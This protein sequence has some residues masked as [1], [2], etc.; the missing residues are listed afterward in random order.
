MIASKLSK[1]I[2]TPSK[3]ASILDWNKIGGAIMSL[4]INSERIGVAIAE[5]PN[6]NNAIYE[7]NPIQASSKKQVDLTSKFIEELATIVKNHKVC[8]FVVNWPLQPEG[9]MGKSCGK[10]LHTLD[11][12]ANQSTKVLS[13]SRPFTLLDDRNV[14][15]II[16]TD[17]LP[18]DYW[19]RSPVFSRVPSPPRDVLVSSERPGHRTSCDSTVAAELLKNFIDVNFGFPQTRMIPAKKFAA[20]KASIQQDF[21]NSYDDEVDNFSQNLL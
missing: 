12:I 16:K 21:S 3:V 20:R 14:N 9:R 4:D 10:V 13:A 5:H 15:L 19:G 6:R 11:S 7:L 8:A 1:T 18:P 17:D 2:V